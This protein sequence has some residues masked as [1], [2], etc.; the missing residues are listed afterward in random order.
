MSE[1]IS[2]SIMLYSKNRDATTNNSPSTAPK[3]VVFFSLECSADG[4]SSQ[5][6]IY[7]TIPS[8][9]DIKTIKKDGERIEESPIIT[10]PPM[11]V[12]NEDRM[13]IVFLF[14]LLSLLRVE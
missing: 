11:N 3:I 9:K 1:K 8:A 4:I 2:I 5:K 6:R 7:N 12:E 14:P 10:K 13:R